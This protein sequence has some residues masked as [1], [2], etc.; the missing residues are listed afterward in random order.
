MLAHTPRCLAAVRA[1]P[2]PLIE[3]READAVA[4]RLS[5]AAEGDAGEIHGHDLRDHNPGT[6]PLEQH[7]RD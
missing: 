7:S 2:A 6:V 5:S 1:T 4:F 3:N